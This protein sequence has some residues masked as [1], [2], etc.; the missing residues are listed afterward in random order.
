MRLAPWNLVQ[1]IHFIARA[2]PSTVAH[3]DG[4]QP[5]PSKS[6]TGSNWDPSSLMMHHGKN[7]GLT[8]TH[9]WIWGLVETSDLRAETTGLILW[10][11]SPLFALDQQ[12]SGQSFGPLDFFSCLFLSI[13]LLVQHCLCES[14][15][16]LTHSLDWKLCSFLSWLFFLARLHT[17]S[18]LSVILPTG[19]HYICLET[20]F[21]SKSEYILHYVS[22]CYHR[23]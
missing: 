23:Q 19:F 8:K 17:S 14:P 10:T 9:Y 1:V 11:R 3:Q 22:K 12:H 5:W 6:H 16:P 4:T 21:S 13:F 20:H 18:F 2:G 7:Y 15:E